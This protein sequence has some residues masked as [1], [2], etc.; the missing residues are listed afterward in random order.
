MEDRQRSHK[1][2]KVHDIVLLRV[3]DLEHPVYKEVLLPVQLEERQG[4]LVLVDETILQKSTPSQKPS[5]TA[6]PACTWKM[7]PR[8]FA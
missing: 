5:A 2:L 8:K 4:E 7:S 3:K 6:S 1:L